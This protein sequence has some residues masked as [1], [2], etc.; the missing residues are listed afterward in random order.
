MWEIFKEEFQEVKKT[1]DILKKKE[2]DFRFS[3]EEI[4]KQQLFEYNNAL[5]S[6]ADAVKEF[7]DGD[8]ETK[9]TK[10]DLESL[11]L[12]EEE[13]KMFKFTEI[14]EWNEIY[15]IIEDFDAYPDEVVFDQMQNYLQLPIN[16]ARDNAKRL[17]EEEL[18][19]K[20]KTVKW[21]RKAIDFY[22]KILNNNEGQTK[23]NYFSSVLFFSEQPWFEKDIIDKNDQSYSLEYPRRSDV[24]IEKIFHNFNFE[25]ITKLMVMHECTHNVDSQLNDIL[26]EKFHYKEGDHVDKKSHYF[27]E[28]GL[29]WEDINT[30]LNDKNVFTQFI[31][32]DN[33]LS[34]ELFPEW[35]K[36]VSNWVWAG[37]PWDNRHEFFTSFMLWIYK[38]NEDNGWSFKERWDLFLKNNNLQEGNNC[39]SYW[40]ILEQYKNIVKIFIKKLNLLFTYKPNPKQYQ[41]ITSLVQILTV[42]FQNLEEKTK[43]EM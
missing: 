12:S 11:S 20:E 10:K 37:H 14:Q 3:Q 42:V 38:L 26:P 2:D 15:V 17:T 8:W 16:K 22:E 19:S 31:K 23:Y 18:N 41:M 7:N 30:Y 13:K 36:I 21:I 39:P 27:S 24:D 29:F 5:K 6:Y 4:K 40:D 25:E 43:I 28:T 33:F 9:W 35:K 34:R 1:K 32:D